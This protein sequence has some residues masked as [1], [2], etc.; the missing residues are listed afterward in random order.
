MKAF[1]DKP[2]YNIG[3]TLVLEVTPS[4]DAYITVLDQ[5]SDP[6]SPER[7]YPLVSDAP[8]KANETFSGGEWA[9]EGPAGA[10]TFEI[11]A[12]RSPYNQDTTEVSEEP[13]ENKGG[14]SKNVSP[15]AKS[16]ADA[17]EEISHCTLTFEIV[18]NSKP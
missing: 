12:S 1:V 11:I 9:I 14:K 6:D 8:V 10:N 7:G 2:S 15:P 18:E 3:Q 13:A 4:A 5:G 17:D 16:K